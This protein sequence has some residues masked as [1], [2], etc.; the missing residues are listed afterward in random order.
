MN[1]NNNKYTTKQTAK[2]KNIIFIVGRK[3]IIKKSCKISTFRWN[4]INITFP[5]SE[6]KKFAN[7]DTIK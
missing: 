6:K 4:F 2:I 3:K 5:F 7:R 1:I